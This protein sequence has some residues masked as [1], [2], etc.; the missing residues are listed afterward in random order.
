MTVL[1]QNRLGWYGHML[2]KEDNSWVK[3]CMEYEVGITNQEVDQG[4][5]EEWLCQRTVKH[6]T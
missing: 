3:Q 4:R 2:R 6:I 5:P 1:Q